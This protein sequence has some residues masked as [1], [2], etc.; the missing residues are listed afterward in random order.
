MSEPIQSLEAE[1]AEA[2]VSYDDGSYVLFD[3]CTGGGHALG[4][5]GEIG[6]TFV[7]A[8]GARIQRVYRDVALSPPL[9]GKG[10]DISKMQRSGLALLI[11]GATAFAGTGSQM[12]LFAVALG[13]VAY[14]AD[15]F[16]K[17]VLRAVLAA[18]WCSGWL[19]RRITFQREPAKQRPE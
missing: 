10:A 17:L 3:Y 7:L 4:E 9:I 8:D 2:I 15:D 13:Y 16:S 14:V 11:V 18:V 12:A 1:E 6:L 5:W 19:Y